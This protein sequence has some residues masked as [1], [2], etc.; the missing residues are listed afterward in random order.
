MDFLEG[1]TE[2]STTGKDGSTT[3][4][5]VAEYG[6]GGAT[7]LQMFGANDAEMAALLLLID[8]GVSGYSNREALLDTNYD[9]IGLRYATWDS[10]ALLDVVVAGDYTTNEPYSFCSLTM[11]GESTGALSGLAASLFATGLF[12][13]NFV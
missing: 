2:V 13:L 12:A 10:T 11:P 4:D 8:D 6:V 5:R 3:A 9:S 1:S 7:E